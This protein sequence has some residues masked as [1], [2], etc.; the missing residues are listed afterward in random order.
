MVEHC[1]RLSMALT[2]ILAADL[3]FSGGIDRYIRK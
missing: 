3:V 2:V 1:P